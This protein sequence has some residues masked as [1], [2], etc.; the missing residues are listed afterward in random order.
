MNEEVAVAE[1]PDVPPAGTPCSVCKALGHFCPADQWCAGDSGYAICDECLNGKEC[2]TVAA[3][4]SAGVQASSPVSK[5]STP[6][7]RTSAEILQS[8]RGP[9]I[10][11]ADSMSL[12]IKGQFRCPDGVSL[13]EYRMYIS[14]ILENDD[15]L[16]VYHWRVARLVGTDMLVITKGEEFEDVMGRPRDEDEDDPLKTPAPPGSKNLKVTEEIKRGILSE[17]PCGEPGFLSAQTIADKYGEG[18]GLQRASGS[19]S[20]CAPNRARTNKAG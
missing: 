15:D 3:R 6:A 16:S 11:R 4:K 9:F 7:R 8:I 17:I 10:R 20:D 5:P 1:K 19:G 18:H 13:D 12:N 14:E 2:E